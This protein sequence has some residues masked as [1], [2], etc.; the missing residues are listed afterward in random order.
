MNF[1]LLRS[2]PHNYELAAAVLG[3]INVTGCAA[4]A[5]YKQA[6]WLAYQLRE[7]NAVVEHRPFSYTAEAA[8]PLTLPNH[9]SGLPAKAYP[10]DVSGKLSVYL[11]TFTREQIISFLEMYC[12]VTLEDVCHE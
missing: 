5:V 10:K 7:H 6:L 3:K 8:T 12:L 1:P 2:L 9:L 11:D 4:G